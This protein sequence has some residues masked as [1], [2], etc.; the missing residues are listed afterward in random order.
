M[1]KKSFVYAAV[2]AIMI[3]ML[4][5]AGTLAI[6]SY[7]TNTVDNPFVFVGTGKDKG[8]YGA[9]TETAWDDKVLN[10]AFDPNDKENHPELI[11][12]VPSGEPE[13]LG[14]NMAKK[15]LP[16][17]IIPKDPQLTNASKTTNSSNE[18]W[19]ATP[20]YAAM[21]ITFVK[22]GKSDGTPLNILEYET[23]FIGQDSDNPYIQLSDYIKE[24]TTKGGKWLEDEN[25][26][27]VSRIFYWVD[28]NNLQNFAVL[29]QDKSTSPLFTH[30]AVSKNLPS[31]IAD[32]IVS[33]GGYNIKIEGAVCQ[34]EYITF[35][36]AKEEL[37]GLLNN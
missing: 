22:G 2:A 19:G 1:K 14:I 15:V 25:N 36:E 23:N 3:M 37:K 10:P 6:L 17:M 26:T 4:A 29:E 20:I 28:P 24:D 7:Q 13:N 11:P 9:I 18:G 32:T 33:W 21:K 27:T 34:A 35:D 16:G 12:K 5:V 31:D 30:V 8:I